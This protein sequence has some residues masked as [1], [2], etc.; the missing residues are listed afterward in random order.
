MFKQSIIVKY[1]FLSF[2]TNIDLDFNYLDRI[3][4]Y[5]E[6]NFYYKSR[7]TTSS[8]VAGVADVVTWLGEE[9]SETLVMNM[10]LKMIIKVFF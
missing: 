4:N 9:R 5:I 7:G 3:R 2:F 8:T 6:R 10:L 1:R